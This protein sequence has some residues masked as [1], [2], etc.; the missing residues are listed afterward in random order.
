MTESTAAIVIPASDVAA[1][2]LT[3]GKSDG[4]LPLKDSYPAMCSHQ[5]EVVSHLI[6]QNRDAY[7]PLLIDPRMVDLGG[8]RHL[9][10]ITNVSRR[11]VIHPWNTPY[12][13]CFKRKVLRKRKLEIKRATLVRAVRLRGS[14]NPRS[15]SENNAPLP[16]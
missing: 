9:G 12:R 4:R 5:Q 7:A 1:V 3:C 16:L 2:F 8:E 15:G 6:S 13:W 10:R 11:A 14:Q